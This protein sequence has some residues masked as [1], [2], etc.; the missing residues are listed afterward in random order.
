LTLK[1]LYF[2]WTSYCRW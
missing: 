1:V 2:I